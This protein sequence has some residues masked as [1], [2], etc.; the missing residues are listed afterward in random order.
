VQGKTYG[1]GLGLIACCDI[2]IA[3]TDAHFCFSEV[4]IG[5]IPAVISPYIIQAIGARAAQRFFLTAELFSAETAQ[6]LGLIHEL[7]D[8]EQLSTAADRFCDLLLQNNPA[9][10][11][12]AKQLIRTV[13][14][15]PINAELVEYTAKEIAAIRVSDEGQANLKAFFSKLHS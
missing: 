4:H 1:G 5:L 3:S 8:P 11:T 13:A 6:Q 12:A 7:V 14:N 10:L 2:A 9:A 15:Q